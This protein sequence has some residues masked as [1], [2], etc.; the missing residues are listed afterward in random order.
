MP[1]YLLGAV[2][3]HVK[4]VADTL[5]SKY[6]IRTIYG[7]G[8]GSIAGSDHP[9]GLALDFMTSSKATGDSLADDLI[10]NAGPYAVKYIVWWKKSWNPER[11]TWDNYTSTSNPHYDHVHVSFKDKAGSG[12]PINTTTPVGLP[13]TTELKAL[14]DI[15]KDINAI[16]QWFT[17]AENWR[18]IGIGAAGAAL[19]VTGI[20]ALLGK[21]ARDTAPV[22]QVV[23]AVKKVAKK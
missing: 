1:T 7:I 21:N 2:K 4:M 5:G 19:V 18:R 17:K 9:K 15:G 11:G 23:N 6:G 20:V 14:L 8:P 13:G 16:V 10:A 12:T 3:P 22:V